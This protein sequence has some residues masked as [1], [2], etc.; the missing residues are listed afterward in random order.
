MEMV[1]FVVFVPESH[2]D[3]VR[4]AMGESGAG[5]IGNYAHCS[6]SSKGVGRFKPLPGAHP[7]VGE[8]GT[9]ETVP[10]ERIEVVC[11]K[12]NL[13]ALLAAVKAAHPYEEVAYDVYPLISVS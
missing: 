11:E 6:F 1:K 5:S 4:D 8:V 12:N 10:E 2:A 13:S 3:A 7:S 9:L